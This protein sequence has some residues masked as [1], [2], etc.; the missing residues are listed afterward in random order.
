M[1]SKFADSVLSLVT[2]YQAAFQSFYDHNKNKKDFTLQDAKDM[3]R[4]FWSG[5]MIG[6]GMVVQ[7]RSPFNF[8]GGINDI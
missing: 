3:T 8:P 1:D 5:T 7:G 2:T 4:D 6:T